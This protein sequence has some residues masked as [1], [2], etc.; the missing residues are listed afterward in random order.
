[1]MNLRGIVTVRRVIA[2]AVAGA[3]VAGGVTWD[4]RGPGPLAFSGGEKVSLADYKAADPTGVPP[5]LRQASLVE[6]GEYLAR[7]A[8]C[9][10]CHTAAGGCVNQPLR[11]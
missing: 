3:I 2:V 4:I 5:S 11:F 1:M 10:V 7:A 6:R 8:D 9:M